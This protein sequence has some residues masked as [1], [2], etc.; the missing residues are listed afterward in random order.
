MSGMP[1]TPA[2]HVGR[3]REEQEKPSPTLGQ[4]HL[5]LSICSST[6][7]AI[8]YEHIM[9]CEDDEDDNDDDD[10]IDLAS[11]TT[12]AVTVRSQLYHFNLLFY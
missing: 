12:M 3:G 11:Y 10:L 2:G 5:G 7:L 1:H 8:T 4:E 6:I 9:F